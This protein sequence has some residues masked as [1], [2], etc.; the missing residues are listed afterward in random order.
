MKDLEPRVHFIDKVNT[1]VETSELPEIKP[2]L[3]VA[4]YKRL[5]QRGNPIIRRE[6]LRRLAHLTMRLAEVKLTVDSTEQLAQ[7][8]PA[9][10]EATFAEAIRL[11]KQFLKEHPNY[12]KTPDIKYQLARAY[13]LNG[14]A[15]NSLQSLDEI[16]VSPVKASSYVESQFRRAESYF[17]RK[18]YLIA[19][20]AY[21]EV[22]IKGKDTTYYNKALYKRGWSLF[23]QSLFPEAQEDFF[24]LLER[25]LDNKVRAKRVS[26]LTEDLVKDTKRVISL[27]F[28]NQ[29]GASSVQKY[30][31]KHG[32]RAYENQIYDSL[33]QLYIE[34]ERFQD[35]SNTYLGF[36]DRNPLSVVAPDFHSRV[37][38]IYKRGGFPSLI[39]PAKESYV[40]NYGRNS[41]F[42]QKHKG[43]I[44]GKLKPQLRKHL[45]DISKFY[46]AKA[47]KSKKASDFIVAAKWYQEILDTF[48][49]PAIDSQYR[50]Y[51]A[52]ALSEGQQFLQAAKE[53][54]II[55]YRNKRSK[56]SRDAAYRALVAYQSIKYSKPIDKERNLNNKIL[57]GLAFV[58]HFSTDPQA[59]E[60]LARVTEQQLITQDIAGAIDSSRQLLTLP[61]AVTKKQT[62]RALVIIS[63]GLFDLKDY[64]KAEI[65]ITDLFRSVNLTKKQR[66]SFH[67]RRAESIYKQAEQ[68]KKENKLDVAISLFLKV[69]I[70]EPKSPVAI[71]AHYDAATIHLQNKHWVKAANL[72]EGFRIKYSRHKLAKGIPEKLAYIYEEQKNWNKAAK[73]YQSLAANNT[74]KNSAREGYWHVAD[75]Y[76]KSDNQIKAVAAF[77]YYVKA[78]P[79][80]YLLAQEARYN[81]VNL[82]IKMKES[83][84]SLFWRKKIVLQYKK[85]KTMNNTRTMFLAAES[86][87]IISQPLFDHYK[88]IKLTDPLTRSLKKKRKAM[89]LA[90]R[91]YESIAGYKIAEYTSASTHKIAR[92][93]QIL[94]DDLMNSERPKALKGKEEELE[95]YGFLLEDQAIPFEDKAIRYFEINAER[96]SSHIY[97]Q[98]V[99]DSIT[100]LKKLKP[101]QYN[102]SEKLEAIENVSF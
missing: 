77:K 86:E 1:P 34:Q 102:K 74:D 87:F 50:F 20:K 51:M 94:A 91:A 70:L 29:D 92:I 83:K 11:Y 65:A 64:A 8:G 90:L 68:A 40:V 7:L 84:K 44:T 95:E 61:A 49:D 38:D 18:K 5:L 19:E 54:E 35:A 30:F 39:L 52:E 62:D 31:D 57:S 16:A 99:K 42:W 98:S 45:E 24:V 58:E 4:S 80:P 3:V 48:E 41:Q 17:V 60:I 69:G 22:I 14:E 21:T 63:N 100:S 33:A 59:A 36:V 26:K 93:Y 88:N 73:E 28:Y 82:Y 47:Q 10:R 56:Y 13:S 2:E 37:I 72:F 75:L 85:S 12:E 32:S 55:A 46:H 71:N 89:K 6:A 27:A 9:V 101:V 25:L 81:L 66:L 23:K 43:V 78:Y 97:N 15:E 67:Q 96:T 53:F 76:Q 79:Q